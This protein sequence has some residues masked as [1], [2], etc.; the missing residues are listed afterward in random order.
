MKIIK[1]CKEGKAVSDF[2]IANYVDSIFE[3]N[4]KTFS[5]STNLVLDEIRKRVRLKK[6]NI[7][8]VLFKIENEDG[9]L[10]DVKLNEYGG[11]AE[12]FPSQEVFLRTAIN[13]T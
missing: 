11:Q 10:V 13:L 12:Y 4:K 7:S 2:E 6:I 5:V 1:F 9:V 8:D 3:S